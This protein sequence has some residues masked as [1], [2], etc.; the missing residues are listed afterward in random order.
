MAPPQT[1]ATLLAH[2]IDKNGRRVRQLSEATAVAFGPDERVPHNS[3]S[4]WVRGEVKKPRGWY[5]V[6]KVAAVLDLSLEELTNLLALIGH[7]ATALLSHEPPI[8]SLFDL[9]Q[10][11]ASGENIPFQAPPQHP[12]IVGRSALCATIER[13]L[14]SQAQRRVCCLV[15]TAGLGKTHLA[16]HTAYQLRHYFRDGVVWIDLKNSR[17]LNA[18]LT[19]ASAFDD[20]LAPY[21]DVGSG[22]S[23]LRE[24]LANKQAL[25]IFD[26]AD[27]DAQLQALLPPDGECAVL[28]TSRRHDLTVRDFAYTLLL[29]PFREEHSAS[30]LIFEQ[31][32]GHKWVLAETAVFEAIAEAVGHLP[33]AVDILSRRL[34][35]ESGWAAQSLLMQ[36][37]T[38][39]RLLILLKRGGQN[40]C[41]RIEES[42]SHLSEP[43]RTFFY[44]L[45]IFP[46]SFAAAPLAHML[47]RPLWEIEDA[48]RDM[49]NRSLL[50][51]K[52]NN[53][54]LLHPLWRCFA[55]QQ[56]QNNDW[57]RRFVEV[58]TDVD[59]VFNNIVEEQPN[60]EAAILMGFALD[61][62]EQ[63][64]TAVL[65]MTPFLQQSGQIQL[66][67]DLLKTAERV[68]RHPFN[69]HD[70]ARILHL[71]GFMAMKQGKPEAAES[72]YQE[73]YQL[74]QQCGDKKERADIL[75]KLGALAYRRSRLEEAHQ[76]YSEGL[77]EARQLQDMVLVASFLANLG[78]VE[79]ARG[80]I[81]EAITHYE[82]ALSLARE[83]KEA[84]IITNI[85]QNL[86]NMLEERGDYAQAKERYDEG[87]TLAKEL[88]DPEL[89]SRML[90]NLGAVMSHLG[91]Y[92]EATA[93]FRQGLAHAE[94]N[95]LPVQMYRQQANL[96]QTA[97]H[98]GEDRQ[99]TVHFNEALRIARGLDFPEDLGLI[100]NQAGENYLS[101]ERFQEAK[102][103]FGEALQ[104][105]KEKSLQR[106]EPLSLFGLA[107]VTAKRGNI[108]EARR[109]AMQSQE[110][111]SQIGHRKANEVWW[112]LQE[113]PSTPEG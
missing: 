96:G 108:Q 89:I 97:M 113:L 103:A 84:K 4:R 93:Y 43:E 72:Y 56:F 88:R 49:A 27:D 23:K 111:L 45:S 57:E 24:L 8:P 48:L 110:Q 15:G 32:L 78:L 98:R 17:T 83:A 80:G 26:H 21:C 75:L 2:F 73:A 9:W 82:E 5:E 77:I 79:A 85:L 66:A 14:S 63:A 19:I 55:Q 94:S 36:L 65:N 28:I 68:C 61:R 53:R 91:N 105:A 64:V 67:A 60:I 50:L 102:E 16:V 10:E 69:P 31:I 6:V 107:R 39:E 33:L 95:E 100:L 46:N 3:I 47:E 81:S 34:L 51:E 13:Y 99:A 12:P 18:M 40:V 54:Y 58:F 1:F 35:Y 41:Q 74:A 59:A 90:G 112:W 30:L 29:D 42:L 101:Q 86:G 38:P 37:Q 11:K 109:L 25:L 92:A 87:L 20:D 104:I 44:Q 76:F 22:S 52:P 62:H 106:V 70:L 7:D 71:S